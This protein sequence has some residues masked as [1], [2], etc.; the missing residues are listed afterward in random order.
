VAEQLSYGR[1]TGS[2]KALR[3]RGRAAE[4]AVDIV[5]WSEFPQ[6][7]KNMRAGGG[8]T[9]TGL[10]EYDSD[11]CG[12]PGNPAGSYGHKSDL[13]GNTHLYRTRATICR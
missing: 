1:V 10:L 7:C 3:R 9:R 6:S 8:V 5:W 12:L 11:V 13:E 2:N 4:L